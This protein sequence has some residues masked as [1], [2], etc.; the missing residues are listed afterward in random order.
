MKKK[1][2]NSVFLDG[3]WCWDMHP[4]QVTERLAQETEQDVQI[5]CYSRV[6]DDPD[7]KRDMLFEFNNILKDQIRDG[8]SPQNIEAT[9]C[10]NTLLKRIDQQPSFEQVFKEV[11][12]G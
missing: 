5:K 8:E 1:M 10:A 2:N 6:W 4:F 11:V 12:D 7:R 3:D 9:R